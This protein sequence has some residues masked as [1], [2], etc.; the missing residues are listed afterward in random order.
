MSSGPGWE[1]W[2][3]DCVEMIGT[4]MSPDEI[5]FSVYSPP[6]AQLYSYSDDPRDMSNTSSMDEFIEQYSFLIREIMRVTKPGRLSSVHCMVLPTSKTKDGFI[7]LCDFPG[8]IVAAHERAGWIWH[9]DVTIWKDPV[10]QMQRTK[11]LGL[12]HK[13]I[14][15]DSAMSRMGLIDRVLTFRKPG[16]NDVPIEH[17]AEEFP[18]SQWQKWASPVWDDIDQSDTLQASSARDEDDSRHLCP[19]QLGVIRRCLRLWSNPGDMVLSPFAGI[20]SEG[21]VAIDE[22]RRFVGVELKQSYYN[23]AERNLRAISSTQGRMFT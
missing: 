8:L 6:F 21:Y 19:L 11:A 3:G 4:H 1:L 7:G 13:Q 20:G 12:L 9:S 5:D 16:D 17:T 23:Q 18:V 10:V 15:K 22:R 2:Q 14:K